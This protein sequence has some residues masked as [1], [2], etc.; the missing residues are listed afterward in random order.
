MVGE[1]VAAIPAVRQTLDQLRTVDAQIHR[2]GLHIAIIAVSQVEDQWL[3][4][5]SVITE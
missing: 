2:V 5:Q 4:Q 3:A 1:A